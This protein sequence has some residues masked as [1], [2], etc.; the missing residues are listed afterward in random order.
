MTEP[1][2]SILIADDE[3]G[4]RE[5]LGK[6]LRMS[7]DVTLAEDGMTA[8]NLIERNDYDLVLSDIRMG[9]GPDGL[10]VLDATLRK[11]PPPPCIL[12]TAY[13]SIENA[14]EAVKHGAFDFVA[15]PV[16]IDR[17]ELVIARAL[18]SGSLKKEN[19]ELKKQKESDSDVKK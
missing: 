3:R 7:Y 9:A 6:F 11:E 19:K 5:T 17:L 13:G 8:I 12:F 1:K 18:E 15:K 2:K 10:N 14:V 4:T 16:N